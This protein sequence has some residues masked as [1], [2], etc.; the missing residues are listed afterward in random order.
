MT[1][2][3]YFQ[4][5]IF[6]AMAFGLAF[7]LNRCLPEIK[8]AQID[9]K[10]IITGFGPL[11]GGLFC[12]QFFGTKNTHRISLSGVRPVIRYGIIGLAVLLPLL[13]ITRVSKE[14]ISFSF[15]TQFSVPIHL[16][17]NLAGGATC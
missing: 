15:I 10:T 8:T 14:R 2:T 7:L 17:K 13:L 6:Y 4:V 12:Y 16:A 3:K 9:I 11:L 5:L 1:R